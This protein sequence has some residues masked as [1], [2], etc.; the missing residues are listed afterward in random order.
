MVAWQVFFAAHVAQRR[1]IEDWQLDEAALALDAPQKLARLHSMAACRHFEPPGSLPLGAGAPMPEVGHY[2]EA[3]SG[4]QAP[5]A[6]AGQ[7]GVVTE[8]ANGGR[9]FKVAL[10]DG[11]ICMLRPTQ[12]ISS[13]VTEAVFRAQGMAA[14]AHE[15]RATCDAQLPPPS[16][17]ALAEVRRRIAADS[18]PLL[19]LLQTE[20]LR[21][22]SSHLS[23]QDYFAA[24][25]LASEGTHLT[26][27]PPWQWSAW[28]ANAVRLGTEMGP[29]FGR[30][31]KRAAG[32]TADKLELN[33]KLGGDRCTSL[34]ALAAMAPSSLSLRANGI[35]AGEAG[36]LAEMVRTNTSLTFLDLRYNALGDEACKALAVALEARPPGAP[37]LSIDVEFQ[38]M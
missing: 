34:R 16:R 19:S 8:V 29:P 31:L 7:R 28:W 3:V 9:M 26:G 5:T 21:L 6:Y 22:Q 2:V 17:E 14:C 18:L 30:G 1:E 11:M 25:A 38:T 15:L 4:S 10:A 37:P 13:G 23:F 20:P 12:L 32:V 27:A 36:V 24:L 33:H 35:G